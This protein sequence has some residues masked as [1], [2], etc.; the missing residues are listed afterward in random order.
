MRSNKNPTY[1][2]NDLKLTSVLFQIILL[3]HLN[4]LIARCFISFTDTLAGLPRDNKGD[5]TEGRELTEFIGSDGR[6]AE[7]RLR[8][9]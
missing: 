6:K 8:K 3:C 1:G 5:L 9:L 7:Y 4:S 2:R